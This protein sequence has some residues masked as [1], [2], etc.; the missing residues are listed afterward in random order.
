MKRCW[1][2]LFLLM[3]CV[4]EAVPLEDIEE[5]AP[6]DFEDRRKFEQLRE[7]SLTALRLKA[8]GLVDIHRIDPRI[9]VD[10]RYAGNTNF[11]HH[12]LY[13]TLRQL[14][15]QREVAE[16]LLKAQDYL[17]SLRPGFR[18]LIY[19]GVRPRQ[20]QAE[21]WKAL[22]SIP[23]LNR[24]KF[25]SNPA[26]G[27]V[28]NFGAAVDLTIVDQKGNPLDMGA[29]Y[30]DF[31]PIAFPSREAYFLKTGELSRSQVENRKLLRQVMRS[32]HFSNI[33]S[34]WWHF[35]AFSRIVAAQKFEMLE[36][37]SGGSRW[38]RIVPTAENSEDS[39]VTE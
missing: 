15:V 37:E 3:S 24:G 17:D 16:R 10:L 7:D 1:P 39:L 11:M 33:P 25:V 9:L 23:V 19:D 21:M 35:N 6:S 38:F 36:T 13:D 32:Q 14:F 22:D 5:P 26:L 31:R 28:H 12:Q 8:I 27:S 2:F 18:L 34:E 4:Q 20:V 30:D 29:G